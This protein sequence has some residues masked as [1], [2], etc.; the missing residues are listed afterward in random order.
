MKLAGKVALVTGG[1]GGIGRA[2]VSRFLREGADVYA[3]DLSLEGSLSAHDDDGSHFIKLD[4]AA[5][6]DAKAAAA[7][8]QA[9]VLSI[10]VPTTALLLIRGWPLTVQPRVLCMH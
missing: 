4:V 7:L 5:E 2:I 8:A 6:A 9:P 1:R 3:A 10:L